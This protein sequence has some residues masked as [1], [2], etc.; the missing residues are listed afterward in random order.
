MNQVRIGDIFFA[1]NGR[2][3]IIGIGIVKSKPKKNKENTYKIERKVDWIAS[4]EDTPILLTNKLSMNAISALAC[5]NSN[6]NWEL[7]KER[8]CA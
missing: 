5:T 4:F 8:A 6:P 1:A 7:I 3:E 2:S